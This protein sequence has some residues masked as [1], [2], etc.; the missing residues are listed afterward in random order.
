MLADTTDDT[1]DEEDEAIEV[2]SEGTYV[3]RTD[4]DGVLWSTNNWQGSI[5]ASEWVEGVDNA[6]DLY[7]RNLFAQNI[8]ASGTITGNGL[9]IN[10]N[11]NIESGTIGKFNIGDGI[12]YD[13]T[14]GTTRTQVAVASS[15]ISTT[16]TGQG[17]TN[18]IG[19]ITETD[20]MKA[21]TYYGNGEKLV[22][23]QFNK[24]A[25]S[26]TISSNSWQKVLTV[27]DMQAGYYTGWVACK[28]AKSTSKSLRVALTF[29]NIS[30][31]GTEDIAD[32]VANTLYVDNIRLAV[33]FALTSTK[34]V[35]V[36]ARQTRGSD[37]AV[38]PSYSFIYFSQTPTSSEAADT[39]VVG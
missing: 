27:K 14:N 1:A 3:W 34:P 29:A 7:I 16:V 22:K 5:E 31:T 13:A 30:P 19:G 37:L 15:G 17:S 23:R 6:Q 39:E 26:V 35:Y 38:T 32:G 33:S 4:E 36:W 28:F 10:G 18:I 9:V 8:T 20:V 11:A 2:P 12:Q 25:S 21:S 24:S